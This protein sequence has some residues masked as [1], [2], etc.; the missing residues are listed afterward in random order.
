ME[1][2]QVQRD[3]MSRGVVWEFIVEKALWQGQFCKRKD[4]KYQTFFEENSWKISHGLQSFTA[5]LVEIET[6]VKIDPSLMFMTMLKVF[7]TPLLRSGV[8]GRQ[9][10][11]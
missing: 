1:S 8:D 10:S 3:I 4:T 5:L 9:I 6:T 11:C 7:H 2:T